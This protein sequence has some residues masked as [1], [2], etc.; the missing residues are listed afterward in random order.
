MEPKNSFQS[1]FITSIE[2]GMLFNLIKIYFILDEMK[3]LLENLYIK[4][5]VMFVTYILTTLVQQFKEI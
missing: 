5:K 3:P 1:L 2:R 4:Y